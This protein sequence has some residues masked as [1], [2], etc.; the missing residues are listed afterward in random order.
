M[1]YFRP[2]L[3]GPDFGSVR[4]K[5]VCTG[6][7]W[8]DGDALNEE[9]A[10]NVQWAFKNGDN[11]LDCLKGLDPL[12]TDWDAKLKLYDASRSIIFY[13]TSVYTVRIRCLLYPPV[14]SKIAN[15]T[16]SHQHLSTILYFAS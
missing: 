2:L 4:P 5:K 12:H 16:T 3:V 11:K 7:I 6:T 9:R 1:Y 10:W 15:F 13:R 14:M 8:F